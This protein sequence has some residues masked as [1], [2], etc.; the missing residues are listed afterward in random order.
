MKKWILFLMLGV[1][2]M[3]G[4]GQVPTWQWARQGFGHG[5]GNSI[6]V[7][8]NGNVYFTGGYSG[9]SII[10]GNDTLINPNSNTANIFLAK[11]DISGNFIWSKNEGGSGGDVGNYVATDEL[12]NAYVTGYFG[13]SSITFGTFT[14]INN[15]FFLCKYDS[16]GN[17]IWARSANSNSSGTTARCVTTNN[18]NSIY[19]VGD[20][21]DSLVVFGTDTLFNSNPG[22]S[23]IF[24]VKYDSAG[25][26]LWVKSEGGINLDY[27]MSADVTKR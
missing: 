18:F 20:F 5:E 1:I 22:T 3:R 7:D 15:G 24:I 4:M 21:T 6:S 16:L 11:Y 26:L 19:V 17:V 27:G 9:S 2:G 25:S 23:D 14:L 12:G 13:S 8:I 10:F